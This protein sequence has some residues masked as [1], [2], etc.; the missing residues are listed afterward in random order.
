MLQKRTPQR[1]YAMLKSTLLVVLSSAFVAS[2]MTD[3]FEG[4]VEPG[5]KRDSGDCTLAPQTWL[6]SNAYRHYAH[7]ALANASIQPDEGNLNTLLE[8]TR[9]ATQLAEGFILKFEFTTVESS[10]NSSVAYSEEQ[11]PPLGSEANGHCQAMFRHYGV[12]RLEQ[13]WCVP[14]TKE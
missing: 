2:Q 14:R 4:C 7:L 6:S 8:M 12:M 9:I 5:Q 3:F 11:C 1:R 13:A 10:C